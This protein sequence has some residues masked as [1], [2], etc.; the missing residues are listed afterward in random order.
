[1]LAIVVTALALAACS[2]SATKAATSSSSS[3]GGGD[4]IDIAVNAMN[5]LDVSQI[6]P[7]DGLD[8]AEQANL[9]AQ[10]AVLKTAHPELASGGRCNELLDGQPDDA[11]ASAV[12]SRLKPEVLAVLSSTAQ[13]KFSSVGSTIN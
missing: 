12:I 3:S 4:C 2:S 6:N 1:L 13:E 9:D 5:S 7:I 8:S 11:T 10:L